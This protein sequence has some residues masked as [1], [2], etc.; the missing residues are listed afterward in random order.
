[1]ELPCIHA[2]RLQMRVGRQASAYT[3]AAAHASSRSQP[4]PESMN[5]HIAIC[6]LRHLKPL[7]RPW[8]KML[9]GGPVYATGP[10]Q[11]VPHGV[12]EKPERQFPHNGHPAQL[13]DQR[14]LRQL[15]TMRRS[16]Y[17][18]APYTSEI[19]RVPGFA[20]TGDT[21]ALG[22]RGQSGRHYPFD[23]SEVVARALG[24]V[25]RPLVIPA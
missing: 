3:R 15:A 6:F 11:H 17:D 25:A 4:W 2:E 21:Y 22:G 1:M 12:Q 8:V 23:I 18:I 9:A 20:I 13:A 5:T 16:A 10:A 19:A 14:Q 24:S 7:H